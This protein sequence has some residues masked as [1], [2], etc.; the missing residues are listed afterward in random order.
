MI[1]IWTIDADGGNPRKITASKGF[2]VDPEW[3]RD[4]RSILFVSM[5]AGKTLGF[6]SVRAD[7]AVQPVLADEFQNISPAWSPDGRAIVFVS[8]RPWG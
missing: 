1:D 2:A 8:N 5:D 6:W 3:S 4:G 7:G